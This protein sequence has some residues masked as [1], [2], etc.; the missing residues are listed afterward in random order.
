MGA[1]SAVAFDWIGR[2]LFIANRLASNFEVVR[3][4]GKIRH[5]A[6]I[7]ANDGNKTS[8]ADPRAICL[9][10]IEGKLYWTDAGGN[11]VPPKI[12]KVSRVQPGN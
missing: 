3:V 11:G 5:R 7:L 1:P 10:P 6:I 12:A 2:N 8:V 9:D 4:D